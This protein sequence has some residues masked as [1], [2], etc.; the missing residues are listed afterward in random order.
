[1]P[2]PLLALTIGQVSLR[3]WGAVPLIM[4]GH[5]LLELVVI[6]LL[7]LGLVQVLRRTTPRGIIS[8]VGGLLL[9]LMGLDMA[10]RAGG[11]TLQG[12]GAAQALSWPA[13]VLNGALIS[14]ANPTFAPWWATIGG[15]GMAQLGPRSVGEY[16]AF[17]LGHELSDFAWYGV[18][19]AVLVLGRGWLS[20]TVYG[21]LVLACGVAIVILGA[22]FLVTG[23]QIL[24]GRQPELEE[25]VNL[26]EIPPS[27]E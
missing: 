8:T 2:G 9:I 10:R 24:R 26:E 4:L 5:A 6:G 23:V 14:L 19:G 7:I 1:M 17:Y 20:P 11:M 21:G 12:P 22:W 25:A 15:S 13:L 18:V 27:R 3:G 16:L